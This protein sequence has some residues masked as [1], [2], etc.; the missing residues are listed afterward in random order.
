M[1]LVLACEILWDGTEAGNGDQGGRLAGHGMTVAPGRLQMPVHSALSA[2]PNMAGSQGRDL[3]LRPD[4]AALDPQ[5]RG[6]WPQN[7]AGRPYQ[8]SYWELLVRC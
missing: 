7:R 4:C 1:L 8:V 6:L 3:R 2:I 5:S